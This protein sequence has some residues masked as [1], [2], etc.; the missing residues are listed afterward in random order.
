MPGPERPTKQT[1]PAI[2]P[3]AD[4]RTVDAG[5]FGEVHIVCGGFPCQDFSLAGARAGFA[6]PDKGKLFFDLAK[7]IGIL[8]SSVA[9]LE[10][11]AGLAN[12]DGGRTFDIVLDTLTRL[13]YSV[14]MRLLN[15]GS[16]GL[17]QM[18]ERLFLVC[19]HDRALANRTAPFVFPKGADVASVVA[20]I[21]EPKPQAVPCGR[22]WERTKPNPIDRSGKI[23]WSGSSRAKGAKATESPPRWAKASHCARTLAALE[24]RRGSTWWTASPDR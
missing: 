23:E 12:H 17:P 11:V 19:I 9:I 20:D 15:A 5:A 6:N 10:N 3:H 4:I 1:I 16:F 24:E 2:T 18:R 13:G 14:S 7:Q 8:S 22:A 21:L